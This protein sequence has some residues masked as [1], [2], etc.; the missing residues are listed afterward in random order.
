MPAKLPPALELDMVAH[1]ADFLADAQITGIALGKGAAPAVAHPHDYPIIAL[2]GISLLGALLDLMTRDG[3]ADCTGHRSQ[4]IAPAR[5]E[6]M[7]DDAA[8]CGT[9]YGA[10]YR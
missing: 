8:D 7:T 10:N 3:T 4:V 9:G 2:G 6:L 1:Y 5:S